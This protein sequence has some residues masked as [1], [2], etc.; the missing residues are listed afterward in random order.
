MNVRSTVRP[1]A[2]DV[3]LEEHRRVLGGAKHFRRQLEHRLRVE[4]VVL[5]LAAPLVLPAGLQP[6]APTWWVQSLPGATG[7]CP[8]YWYY[9]YIQI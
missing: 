8:D 1:N 9:N 2:V 6:A 5:A 3:V 4:Q 7:L